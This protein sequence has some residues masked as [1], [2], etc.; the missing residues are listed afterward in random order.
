MLQTGAAMHQA[1]LATVG[2]IWITMF[3]W[4]V[5]PALTIKSRIPGAPHGVKKDSLD[6]LLATLAAFAMI[7][8]HGFNDSFI[9]SS[10]ILVLTI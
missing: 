1:F 5:S 9:S 3:Y 4:L 2:S 6:W 8:H 10:I 7:S